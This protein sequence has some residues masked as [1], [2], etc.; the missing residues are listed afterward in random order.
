M[1][2]GVG[3]Y[4]NTGTRKVTA[5][6]PPAKLQGL[7]KPSHIGDGEGLEFHPL[8]TGIQCGVIARPPGSSLVPGG[9]VCDQRDGAEPSLAELT[10]SRVAAQDDTLIFPRKKFRPLFYVED[11]AFSIGF[12]SVG[13]S[14]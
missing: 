11:V 1:Q 7:L 6:G 9:F 13:T 10:I 8:L 2:G 14:L 12:V 4:A 5:G 3:R